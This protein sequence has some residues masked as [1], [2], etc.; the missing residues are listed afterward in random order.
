MNRFDDII[1]YHDAFIRSVS[2]DIMITDSVFTKNIQKVVK[3][4][5]ALISASDKQIEKTPNAPTNM[6]DEDQ[7]AYMT[8]KMNRFASIYNSLS[9]MYDQT[10]YNLMVYMN[11]E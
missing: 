4:C 10:V 7:L 9:N 11:Q 2:R 3:N 6:A 5:M 1:A 8:N